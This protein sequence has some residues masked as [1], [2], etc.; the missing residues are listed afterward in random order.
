MKEKVAEEEK[1]KK[2]IPAEPVQRKR[3]LNFREACSY[4]GFSKSHLYKLTSQKKIPH[5]CPGGKMLFFNL[6]ELEEWL[7]SGRQ[8]NDDEVKDKASSFV[9]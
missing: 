9:L 7:Q 1:L 2:L 5:Y 6:E 8:S 4:T 3:V